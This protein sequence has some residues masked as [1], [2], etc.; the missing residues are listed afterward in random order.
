MA[1]ESTI[2]GFV[3][4]LAA[5]LVLLRYAAISHQVQ[6]QINIVAAGL[7][8]YV[9]DLAWSVSSIATKINSATVS[10]WLVFCFEAIGFALIAV[11]AIWSGAELL[12]K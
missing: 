10:T 3:L 1:I 2:F 11:G 7:L 12:K 4:G 5:V 9:I 8:F 6:R